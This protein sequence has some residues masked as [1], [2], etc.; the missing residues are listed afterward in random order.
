MSDEIEKLWSLAVPKGKEWQHKDY[1]VVRDS[2]AS[3]RRAWNAVLREK[4]VRITNGEP[5]TVEML[6]LQWSAE[7]IARKADRL[8]KHH[9]PQPVGISVYINQERWNTEVITEKPRETISAV[10]QCGKEALGPTI[11]KCAECLT[12]TDDKEM[13]EYRR[14]SME[15]QGLLP[16]EGESKQ[17]YYSR[18]RV[19]AVKQLK[20]MR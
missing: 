10:C 3:L 11:G 17:D 9:V 8:A 4:K 20:Q 15:R 19:E 14:K 7:A 13:Y 16:K 2:T 18:C 6:E 12:R 1:P 5:V